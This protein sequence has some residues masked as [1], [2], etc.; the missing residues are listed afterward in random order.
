MSPEVTV[1]LIRLIPSGL[2]ILFLTVM[3]AVFYRPIKHRLLPRMSG[4][5]VFGIELTFASEELDKAVAT[6]R[7]QVSTDE[8]SLVLQRAATVASVIRG[9]KI[10][11]V[12][13]NPD[14]QVHERRTLHSLGVSIDLAGSTDEALSMLGQTDYDLVISDMAR[15]GVQ[16]AGLKL[17][18]KMR[19]RG[20]DLATVFYAGAF[21][22]SRGIPPHAFG[23]TS[24]V[25]HLL[26]YVMDILERQ[27]S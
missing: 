11:W 19:E 12:D 25:D 2:W 17:L 22:P 18:E 13:D 4:F 8:R 15:Y 9:G 23:M 3:V 26:H 7:P 14:N 21:D 5:R 20:V 10:L 6:G 27:R 1:E 24:R 16:D